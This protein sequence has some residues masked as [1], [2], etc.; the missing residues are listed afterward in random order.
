MVSTQEA[1]V[2][3]GHIID[4]L[5]LAKVLD[6]ILTMGGDLRPRRHVDWEN[7]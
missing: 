1:V 4:S 7:T 5:I 3:R 2:L 6:I